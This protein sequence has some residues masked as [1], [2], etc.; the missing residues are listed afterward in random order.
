MII[1]E[2]MH[3]IC[4]V[5]MWCVA[6]AALCGIPIVA[7]F[8]RDPLAAAMLASISFIA[9]AAGLA[10]YDSALKIR[11][12]RIEDKIWREYNGS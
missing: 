11:R 7:V 12:N 3:S 6:F 4:C 5:F 10:F 9:W 8:L 1:N 2:I